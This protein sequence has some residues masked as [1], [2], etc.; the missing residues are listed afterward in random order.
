MPMRLPL[1]VNISP[2]AV[3]TDASISPKGGQIKEAI[4]SMTPNIARDTPSHN[5]M[6]IFCSSDTVLIFLLFI[7]LFIFLFKNQTKKEDA[8]LNA[9]S[10]K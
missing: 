9:P 6:V 7:S 3:K 2:I 10:S 8:P 5:W 1:K 4:I